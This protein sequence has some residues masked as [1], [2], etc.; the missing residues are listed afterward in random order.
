[1]PNM[2]KIRAFDGNSYDVKDAAAGKSLK[3]EGSQLDLL[4]AAGNSI[5]SVDIPAGAKS[6]VAFGTLTVSNSDYANVGRVDIWYDTNFPDTKDLTSIAA[7]PSYPNVVILTILNKP[8]RSGDSGKS[9]DLY[10]GGTKLNR[11]FEISGPV[12]VLNVGQRYLFIKDSTFAPGD[13]TF[14]YRVVG[15][16]TMNTYNCKTVLMSYINSDASKTILT[17]TCKNNDTV[18]ATTNLVDF[19]I[20]SDL[21][22]KL[23]ANFKGN[24]ASSII[25]SL[26]ITGFNSLFSNKDSV[27]RSSDDGY[28][29]FIVDVT[30]LDVTNPCA[31][32]GNQKS[33]YLNDIRN[34]KVNLNYEYEVNFINTVFVVTG[35]V[36]NTGGYS[37]FT[38]TAYFQD[39]P[40]WDE[41]S[42]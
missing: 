2:S 31:F 4:N 28:P 1:M 14:N 20:F 37:G 25:N 7:N 15:P 34:I 10:I 12:G 36:V 29:G 27:I 13:T 16:M 3:I 40:R 35:K 24:E 6:F 9:A 21:T 42:I 23:R 33:R 5:S 8:V 11:D 30:Y 41:E 19:V 39:N 18:V 22:F 32:V 17:A 38:P 26:E